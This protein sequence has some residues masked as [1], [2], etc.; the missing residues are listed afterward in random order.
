MTKIT[1]LSDSE[2]LR[3]AGGRNEAGAGGTGGVDP[4]ESRTKSGAVRDMA[5]R[6]RNR[7]RAA[8]RQRAA[9]RRRAA[10]ERRRRQRNG[11]GGW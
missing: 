5:N 11:G 1:I 9:E 6:V 2:I 8:A 4:T 7:D 10:A 3:V